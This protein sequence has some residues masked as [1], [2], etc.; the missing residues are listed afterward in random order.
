MAEGF[1]LF[2]DGEAKF[3]GDRGRTE[4]YM[5][6][7]SF[8][9]DVEKIRRTLPQKTRPKFYDD[10]RKVYRLPAGAYDWFSDVCD[11]IKLPIKS[12]GAPRNSALTM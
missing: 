4:I 5:C 6:L 2:I 10:L 1:E 12:V 3:C 9:T 8:M 11:D 7:I